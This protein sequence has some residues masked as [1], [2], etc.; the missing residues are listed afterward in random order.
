MKTKQCKACNKPL[1]HKV[2]SYCDRKCYNSVRV[3]GETITCSVCGKQKYL[4]LSKLKAV[5]GRFCSMPCYRIGSRVRIPRICQK[6]GKAYESEPTRRAK[7][8]S[9]ACSKRLGCASNTVDGYL[10]LLTPWGRMREHRWV[11]AQH[12]GRPLRKDEHVHHKNGNR[13]DNR[14]ENLEILTPSEHSKLHYGCRKTDL[15]G[16]LKPITEHSHF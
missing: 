1:S 7:F 3:A 10:E 15:H 6:C 11:M 13:K 5:K 16:R 9:L 4:P 14:L 12:L 2:I 8:C